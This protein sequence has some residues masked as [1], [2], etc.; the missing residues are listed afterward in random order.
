MAKKIIYLLFIIVSINSFA[1]DQMQKFIGK[2]TEF[3]K[4]ISGVHI[5]NLNRLNGTSTRE[6][7]IFEIPVKLND[8]L[9]ISHI[10]YRTQ[11]IVISEV[12]LNTTLPV[13]IYLEEM[14]N[15]LD[16]VNIKN[17]DLSGILET[18][19]KSVA[20]SA[21]KDSINSEF[22]YLANQTPNVDMG[23]NF[24]KPINSADPLVNSTVSVGVGI[25]MKFKDVEERKKL[26]NKRDFP[27]RI[28]SDFGTAYFTN[29][30]KVPDEKIHHFL[31]Y[32]DSKNIIDLYYRNDITAV[33]TILQEE[34]LEYVKIK[35]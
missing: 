25:P 24:K 5:Y 15:Y 10:K 28:I 9:I 7:G 4:P 20:N 13:N 22:Q 29:T 32:C 17:H 6:N 19:T 34:S 11:R 16:I 2:V 35:D 21:S 8:T 26:K 1:Q 30:L 18:D 33:L 12:Y 14:T 3:Q 23:S 27:K 31:T